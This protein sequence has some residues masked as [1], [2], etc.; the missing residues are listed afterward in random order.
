MFLT[1][2]THLIGFG[3]HKSQEF[4]IIQETNTSTE[5][6]DTTS[7]GVDMPATVNADD[8]LIAVFANDGA[9]TVSFGGSF[10]E[11]F[12]SS[13]NGVQLAVAYKQADGTEGGGSITVTTSASERSSHAVYR[14]TGHINPATQAPEISAGATANSANPDPDSL[15]PT[16][17]SKKYLWLAVQ[18]YDDGTKTNDAIPT[19]YNTEV[20]RRVAFTTGCG[21]ACAN[22]ALAASS[23]DP[24]TFTISGADG[25]VAATIAIHPA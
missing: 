15:T 3:S 1:P 21:V 6:A 16:G 9:G 12:E 18:A 13:G 4:P 14:I 11:I 25:W 22:R 23:E 19:D 17:G 8:L 20:S 2:S 10:T 7:H 24:G 5:V